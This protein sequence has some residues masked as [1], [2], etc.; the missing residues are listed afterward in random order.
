MSSLLSNGTFEA[1]SKGVGW[2]DGWSHPNGSTWEKEGDTRFISLRSSKPDDTVLVYRLLNLP[3]PPPPALEIRLRVRYADIKR[4]ENAWFD[5]GIIGHFKNME[6]KVIKPEPSAPS[7][8]GTSK[9]WVDKSYIV[10]V[11]S[12]A[13]S[14]ELMPCL[15]QAA[16]DEGQRKDEEDQPRKLTTWIWNRLH[17]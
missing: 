8:T 4:G 5:G 13:R 16:G 6:G 12:S 1:D 10:K 17:R 11:P 7:F 3:S 15:F 2:P 9:G 14:L